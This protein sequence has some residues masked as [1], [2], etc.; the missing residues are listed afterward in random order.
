MRL[1]LAA[2]VIV[3]HA[4]Y[5]AGAGEGPHPAGENLGGWAVIGFFIVSG[6]LITGS[7]MA[8]GFGQYLTNRIARLY[9]GF[10]V[11]LLVTVGLFAP[12]AYVLAHH[13]LDGY[14][15]T[16]TTPL[17]YL[18]N[19]FT[20]RIG[21]YDVAG[22]LAGV[23]YPGAWNGSLWTLYYEFLCYLAVGVVFSLAWLRRR[24]RVVAPVLFLGS[25]LVYSQV[26]RVMALA[27]DN[28]DL[29]FFLK[30]LPSFLAGAVLWAFRDRL[31]YNLVGAVLS[32]GASAGLIA[33]STRWGIQAASP[34]LGY[35]ILWLAMAVPAPR[36]ILR[37]DI[38]YGVYIYG[39]ITEQLLA[40]AGAYRLGLVPYMILA[41]IGTVPFAVASWLLV[42]KPAM[43]RARGQTAYPWLRRRRP[44]TAPG[45]VP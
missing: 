34:F 25:V 43:R 7:R 9:P 42:E 13:T 26:D 32:A 6:Y 23:P 40:L 3:C 31:V 10:A 4:W 16:P 19:N 39:W 14:F 1:I 44:I 24:P 8:K 37:E 22:T 17:A 20:L 5:L 15:H 41:L 45:A 18:A 29:R 35:I 2:L 28:F 11:N 36:L 12:L 27:Q 38:S 33:V 30:L 21:T